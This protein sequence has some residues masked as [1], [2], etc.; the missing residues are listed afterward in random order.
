VR[1]REFVTGFGSIAAAWPLAG[2]AQPLDRMRR[3]GILLPWPEYG[4]DVREVWVTDLARN[5]GHF[6]WLAGENIRIDWRFAAGNPTLFKPFAAECDC[7]ADHVRDRENVSLR[8]SVH[9]IGQCAAAVA[10]FSGISLA[11][12]DGAID[13][14]PC[15]RPGLECWRC[16]TGLVAVGCR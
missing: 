7:A 9:E 4:P 13:P 11:A 8:I 16:P 10:A 1:R 12:G 3:V 2:L 14:T 6:G 15:Q 5:L